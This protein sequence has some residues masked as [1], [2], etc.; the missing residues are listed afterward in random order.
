MPP[1]AVETEDVVPGAVAIGRCLHHAVV[2]PEA[3][4]FQTKAVRAFAIVIARRILTRDTN[5]VL[6]KSQDG[7][8]VDVEGLC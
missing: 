2:E 5:Q 7:V 3:V 1:G 4:Q 8:S 6:A